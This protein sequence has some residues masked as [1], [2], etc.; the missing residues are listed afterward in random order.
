MRI[1]PSQVIPLEEID[2]EKILLRIQ[3]AA[4]TCY[5]THKV[6]DNIESAKRIVKNLLASGH[7]SMLEFGGNIA[8]RYITNIA[9]YKDLRTHRHSTWAVE[10]TRWA[11]YSKDKFNN[12]LTFIDPVEIDHNS[13]EYQIWLNSMLITEKNYLE[14]AKLGAKPDQLSLILPQS[15]K[16]ECNV[17]ANIPEWRHILALRSSVARTGH[18]RPC[19]TEIMDKTLELFHE[20]IPVVFDDLYEELQQKRAEQK[21]KEAQKAQLQ[22]KFETTQR[23]K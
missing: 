23:K 8:M 2:G 9:G 16:A 22:I 4:K 12:G 17:I 20:K 6:T 15:L 5:Q 1:I 19:I 7:H 13:P 3:D 14:M 11:N 18:A 10:S 21:L